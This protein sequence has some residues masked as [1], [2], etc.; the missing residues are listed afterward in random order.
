MLKKLDKWLHSHL[1]VLTALL[2]LVFLR[3][4]NLFEPYWYGDEGI[5]L[6]I[7]QAIQDGEKLYTDIVDHKT[8]IIYYLAAVPNQ[9]TF[10]VLTIGWMIGTTL[11]FYAVSKKL[12]KN[13]LAQWIAVFFFVIL[14][15]MPWF[16]GNIPNG[17]LFVMGFSLAGLWLI[18][19]TRFFGF[20]LGEKRKL[21]KL[22]DAEKLYL[23]GA[24]LGLAVMTKVPA[25][26]DVAMMITVGWFILTNHAE[27]WLKKSERKQWWLLFERVVKQLLIVGAGVLTPLFLSVLY[28]VAIGS[29]QDYLNFGLLYNFHYTSNWGLPFDSLIL[30]KLFTLPGKV[31]IAG[32]IFL[33][34]TMRKKWF[35]PEWQLVAGWFALSLIGATLSNRPYP[36]YFQQIMPAF[37]LLVG[38]LI[39]NSFLKEGAEK[40][41]GW[42]MGLT[43]NGLAVAILI[44][45]DFGA[46]PSL[47][48][49][50][51]SFKLMT[52]RMSLE[53]YRQSFNY[54]MTDNYQAAEIIQDSGVDEIFIW[55]T[56]PML[57]ALSGTQPTGRFTVSF[58]IKD[59]GVYEETM[60]SVR[61]KEPQFVVVMKN[62]NEELDG[63]QD[64]LDEHYVLN[65]N[66]ENF[67]LWMRLD[68]QN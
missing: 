17:E 67:W 31:L 30:E 15:T 16:E 46:Y 56:N 55:G 8:P 2:L 44:L 3:I 43:L 21:K 24:L 9:L 37:A 51:K 49:Y 34:L 61:D 7:G 14:T 29:G 41:A 27:L 19:E 38:L 58:H 53:E 68:G 39:D 48:Y 63:L 64:Y 33:V 23:G 28:F 59:L 57:Y 12:L 52:G 40:T 22:E 18:S 54:F 4:P 13:E 10:R 45:L 1:L 26:F 32:L 66:F 6:T 5:Y 35:K 20:F 36:H 60:Q 25:I 11:A 42:L 65:S 62:E 47:E 50:N